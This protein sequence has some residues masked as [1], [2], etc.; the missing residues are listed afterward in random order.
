MNS[1][2]LEQ[3]LKRLSKC[4]ERQ[5]SLR[6]NFAV[7]VL[8]GFGGALGATFVFGLVIAGLVQLIRSIDYV[9]ILNSILNSGTIEEVIRR[10]SQPL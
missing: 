9:P 3:E 10:F 2:S 1:D 4:I 6:R 8:R 7:S 5:N